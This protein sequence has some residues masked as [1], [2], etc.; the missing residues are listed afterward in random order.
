MRAQERGDTLANIRNEAETKEL[1]RKILT[2]AT[3]MFMQK[4]FERT[5]LMDIAK[6]SGVSKRVIIYEMN[7]KE[8]ILG[9]LVTRFLDG[10]TAASDA[11]SKKHTD[12][13][14]L[15]FIANEVLQLYMAEMSED[16]RNLY[17]SG[18]SMPKTSEEVLKRRTDMMYEAFRLRFPEQE[19]K[20]FYEIEIAS[21]GI[22][23]AYMTVPCDM[24][25]TVEAKAKRLVTM[26]LRI[27]QAEDDKIT[28]AIEFIEKIDFATVAKEAVQSVFDELQIHTQNS[29]RKENKK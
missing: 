11:V 12:D 6:L 3:A 2:A 1:Y 27:Y 28:E 23:R 15:I 5:T 14:V 16:M 8:E 24:Y 21:M 22:T 9:L 18:Y 7:S 25:F 19:L 20:D 4:G 17:L 10:V 13:Q 26:L 29:S